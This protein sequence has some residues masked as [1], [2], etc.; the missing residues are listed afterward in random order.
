[1]C[2]CLCVCVRVC[3]NVCATVHV[4]VCAYVHACVC[5][6]VRTC[7]RACVRACVHACMLVYEVACSGLGGLFGGRI[8]VVLFFYNI[9]STNICTSSDTMFTPCFPMTMFRVLY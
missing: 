5:V 7:M 1:M 9:V 6:C 4:P 2:V 3:V 8:S